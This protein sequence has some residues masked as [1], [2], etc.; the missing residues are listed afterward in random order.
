[1]LIPRRARIHLSH[2]RRRVTVV[3]S[4]SLWRREGSRDGGY[5][6]RLR[7]HAGGFWSASFTRVA[8]VRSSPRRWLVGSAQPEAAPQ[9]IVHTEL[10]LRRV[11]AHRSSTATPASACSMCMPQ[12]RQVGLPQVLH[13]VR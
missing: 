13:V 12:P 9:W 7:P 10:A 2:V 1:M 4:S 6:R 8:G 5:R 3:D 11:Q